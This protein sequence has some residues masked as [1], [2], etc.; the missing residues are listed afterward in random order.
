MNLVP[1]K[2]IVTRFK[3]Y[4][5][6]EWSGVFVVF[7][8][9]QL[10]QAFYLKTKGVFVDKVELAFAITSV[11]FICSQNCIYVTPQ[12]SLV[13]LSK[14]DDYIKTKEIIQRLGYMKQ[15]ASVK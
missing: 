1:P 12:N 4:E 5:D 7:L 10:Q 2:T 11:D 15:Y 8:L 13:Q 14:L 6:E 3:N 9:Q